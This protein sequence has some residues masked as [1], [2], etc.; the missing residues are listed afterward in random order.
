MGYTTV[1]TT[2][3]GGLGVLGW[4][5]VLNVG[6]GGASETLHVMSICYINVEAC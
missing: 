2:E 5:V 6:K 1:R 3:G 4:E